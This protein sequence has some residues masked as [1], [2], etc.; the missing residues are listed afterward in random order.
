M[1][2]KRIR[3]DACLTLW[4][5][6]VDFSCIGCSFRNLIHNLKR[7]K[8]E[9][10]LKGQAIKSQK[11]LYISYV[12]QDVGKLASVFDQCSFSWCKAPSREL[13]AEYGKFLFYF[14]FAIILVRFK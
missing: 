6:S 11:V 12:V 3:E 1:R 14:Y 5:P 10:L 8:D 13:D 7:H 2:E 4:Y 9:D